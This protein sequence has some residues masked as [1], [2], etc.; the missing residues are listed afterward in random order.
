MNQKED[1]KLAF[2][3]LEMYFEPKLRSYKKRLEKKT[4][5]FSKRLDVQTIELK[6]LIY[7]IAKKAFDE[8]FS[9]E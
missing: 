6:K 5:K 3:L 9:E 4:K 1:K 7:P 2:Q 8:F